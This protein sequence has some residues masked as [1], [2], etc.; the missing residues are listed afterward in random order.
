MEFYPAV[1]YSGEETKNVIAF[2]PLF[3]RT[4]FLGGEIYVTKP[5]L[6]FTLDELSCFVPPLAF[7]FRT[8][9]VCVSERRK[10]KFRLWCSTGLFF[11]LLAAVFKEQ[12]QTKLQILCIKLRFNFIKKLPALCGEG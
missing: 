4:A 12:E 5:A 11:I 2:L 3:P 9:M 7:P 10:G 8:R 1:G 6:S